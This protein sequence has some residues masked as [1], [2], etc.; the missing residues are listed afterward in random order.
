MAFYEPPPPQHISDA[1]SDAS[2]LLDEQLEVTWLEP[3]LHLV[4]GPYAAPTLDAARD[5][6]LPGIRQE[7]EAMRGAD[8]RMRQHVRI[9]VESE[10]PI[11]IELLLFRMEDGPCN[12]W[13]VRVH[14]VQ[15]R[16]RSL[17]ALRLA[18]KFRAIC[19]HFR[20]AADDLKR[21]ITTLRLSTQL[22][23]D[24]LPADETRENFDRDEWTHVVQYLQEATDEMSAMLSTMLAQMNDIDPGSRSFNLGRELQSV[25]AFLEPQ[26]G[27]QHT[28]V[29]LHNAVPH[30]DMV[31]SR[32]MFRQMVNNLAV[33]ALE[34]MPRGGR[35]EITSRSTEEG[36]VLEV[37]DDGPGMDD[38]VAR[39]CFDLNFSTKAAGHGAG[40][41]GV[42]QIVEAFGGEVGFEIAPGEGTRFRIELPL[43]PP[44][45]DRLV[46]PIQ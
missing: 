41:V 6:V 28:E 10:P 7:I 42:Q 5:C 36:V 4:L 24:G 45:R 33:N 43:Q 31:G 11:E 23:R 26:A 21:P 30:V 9:D 12:H 19:R 46:L 32:D 1:L 35:I 18:T 17:Q 44:K 2:M 20:L 38:D 25:L 39:R 15:E 22:L 34:A 13:L 27:A 29:V 16:A 37:S 14:N 40:L 3:T 8:E